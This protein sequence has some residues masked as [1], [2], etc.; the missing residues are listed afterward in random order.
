MIT[1]RDKLQLDCKN[2]ISQSFQ[3]QND[4]TLI[5]EWIRSSIEPKETLNWRSNVYSSETA[6]C[7]KYNK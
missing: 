2:R 6:F 5:I 1:N 7:Q 4:R 3:S